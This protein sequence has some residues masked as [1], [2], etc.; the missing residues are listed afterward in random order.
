LLEE[1]IRKVRKQENEKRSCSYVKKE[2]S[3]KK[4]ETKFSVV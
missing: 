3:E 4:K 1:S 2:F